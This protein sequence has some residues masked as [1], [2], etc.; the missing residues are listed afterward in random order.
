M[1]SMILQIVFCS[2]VVFTLLLEDDGSYGGRFGTCSGAVKPFAYA[3]GV[4]GRPGIQG[5]C[6]VVFVTSLRAACA[7]MPAPLAEKSVAT[8]SSMKWSPF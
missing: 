8:S 1:L 7:G 6:V 4:D 2:I 5:D 3:A